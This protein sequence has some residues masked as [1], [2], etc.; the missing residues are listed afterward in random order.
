MEIVVPFPPAP[1]T[2]SIGGQQ[3]QFPDF[4]QGLMNRLTASEWQG[5]SR[6]Y[7][8]RPG[9]FEPLVRAC[10]LDTC[11]AKCYDEERAA[12]D[13]ILPGNF[14]FYR[15]REATNDQSAFPRYDAFGPSDYYAGPALYGDPLVWPKQ[16][17]RFDSSTVKTTD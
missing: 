16:S 3:T 15:F 17:R 1:T 2:V 14:T 8:A 5:E 11:N 4:Y 10:V 13:N 9:E 7:C 6:N 12:L